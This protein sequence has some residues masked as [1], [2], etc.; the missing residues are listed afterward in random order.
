[1]W[2]IQARGF[3]GVASSGPPW[4]WKKMTMRFGLPAGWKSQTP[5]AG[6]EPW[7]IGPST[8]ALF[9]YDVPPPQP[10]RPRR[11]AVATRIQVAAFT[12]TY[13][14]P[15][16]KRLA[17][18]LACALEAAALGT[19]RRARALLARGVEIGAALGR[20]QLAH[21]PLRRER[22]VHRAARP[23]DLR[24]RAREL[25]ILLLERGPRCFL[26]PAPQERHLLHLDQQGLQVL[27]ALHASEQDDR[28]EHQ[29]DGGEDEDRD[30]EQDV[31]G[32]DHW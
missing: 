6:S 9:G 1:M 5:F 24:H 12:T 19:V 15:T 17:R 20:R 18:A 16:G 11:R 22:V 27:P 26:Q 28:A 14:S 29:E 13:D 21:R 32:D 25:R 3:A 23:L 4:P 2:S 30:Q 7:T 31:E 8:V 10:A